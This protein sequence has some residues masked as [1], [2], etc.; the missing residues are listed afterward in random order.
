MHGQSARYT[1][2]RIGVGGR[3][4][5]LQCAVVL[6]KLERFDW[7]LQRRHALGA[8]YGQLLADVPGVRT[9]AVRPDRDCVWGQYTVFVPRRAQV[10]AVLQSLGIPTRRAL[11][12]AA[13]PPAGLCAACC[14]PR[15]CPV[16]EQVAEQVLSLPMSADLSRGR[17]RPRGRRAGTGRGE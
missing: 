10:Q 3:M 7:E 12:E 13:A 6:A 9:L 15:S 17:P 5:T 11:S 4:D 8:R 2:T 1:H 16:S 14:G